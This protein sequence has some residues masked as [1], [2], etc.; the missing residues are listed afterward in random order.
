MKI[1]NLP[2]PKLLQELI[3]QGHWKMPKDLTVLKKITES[4]NI[5]NFNV[6]DFDGMQRESSFDHLIDDQKIADIYGLASS[7]RLGKTIT[8]TEILDVDKSILIAVNWNEEAISLDYRTEYDDPR[9]M[10]SI[11]EDDQ[12][13]RW[14]MIAPKFTS[15]AE[16]LY[17]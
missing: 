1:N 8:N 7:K 5:S 9:V 3:E 17:L 12:K 13:M 14:K 15:F 16:K 6:L 2:V 11:W 10:I 4:E